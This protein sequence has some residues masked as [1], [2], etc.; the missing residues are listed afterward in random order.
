MASVQEGNLVR[1]P[2]LPNAPPVIP[3]D[4]VFVL[5]TSAWAGN[6]PSKGPGEERQQLVILALEWASRILCE[7]SL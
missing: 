6:Q 3:K 1:R 7:E 4:C 5:F 2:G